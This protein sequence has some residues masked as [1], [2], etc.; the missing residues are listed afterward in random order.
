MFVAEWYVAASNAREIKTSV[1][2]IT[3]LHSVGLR[4]C[5]KQSQ[6][7]QIV[8]LMKVRLK[9]GN[10]LTKPRYYPRNEKH[11]TKDSEVNMYHEPQ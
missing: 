6:A 1:T 2:T 8:L 9:D 11:S 7:L 5:M 4:S 10:S 3:P